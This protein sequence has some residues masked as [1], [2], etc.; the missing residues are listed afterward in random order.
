M[1]TVSAG[2]AI[3]FFFQHIRKQEAQAVPAP[4]LQFL[5][6]VLWFLAGML[7]MALAYEELR[8]L[9]VEF[10]DPARWSDVI[11]QLETLYQRF[12]RG[13]FPYTPVP[14]P[15]HSPYPVYMPLHWL[16]IGLGD[17][18]GISSRWLGYGMLGLASGLYGLWVGR[19]RAP[20]L[21]RFIALF[22]PS[23]GLWGFIIWGGLELPVSLETIIA[24]Y[25]LLLAVGLLE[26][27]LRLVTLGL[28]C[29]LL[30]RYTLIFWLPLLAY[31]IFRQQALR[32]NIWIW[33]TV[34]LSIL[35]LYVFPFFLKDS[36]IFSKGITHH[37]NSA[38]GEW[39]G[40]GN[41]PVSWSME[42]GIYFA[43]FM[44]PLFSGEMEHRVW[45][46]RVVQASIMLVLLIFGLWAYH[47][48]KPKLH[49]YSLCLVMLY[50]VLTCFYFFSPMTFKYYYLVLFVLSATVTAKVL[51][52]PDKRASG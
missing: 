29:C 49:P 18:L 48:W 3:L 32:Q 8:K 7:P 22:L 15:T 52:T 35:L 41:P 17:W 50:A 10:P 34:A 16:P 26:R 27:N 46:A 21:T 1:F 2:I 51:L 40:Y 37:N 23:L 47:R 19:Q 36:S 25:Y 45:L 31:V 9:F 39:T 44:K 14:L 4:R 12:D 42:S 28:I 11:P 20:W 24:A 33:G 6:G 30:S 43:V 38:V 5:P 13:E